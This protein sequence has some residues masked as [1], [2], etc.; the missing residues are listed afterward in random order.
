MIMSEGIGKIVDICRNSKWSTLCISLLFAVALFA[1]CCLFERFAMGMSVFSCFIHPTRIISVYTQKL[2]ISIFFASLCF[3][4]KR[5]YWVLY[6]LVINAIWIIAECVYMESF[7]DLM[8]DAYSLSMVSNLSGFESSIWM[9]IHSHYI[10]LF[11]PIFL[12]AV[13]VYFFDNRQKSNWKAFAICLLLALGL[14]T[15]HAMY[16]S[17]IYQTKNMDDVHIS[18]VWNPITS[19]LIETSTITYAHD[20]SIVHCFLR[21]GYEMLV[22]TEEDVDVDVLTRE[23]QPFIQPMD[24]V[25]QPKTKLVIFLVESLESW[26]IMPEV[27]PNIC[28]VIASDGSLYAPY[29]KRQALKGQSMDGQILVNTGILPLKNGASCFR[30]PYN[31]F[32]AIS[33][34]YTTSAIIVPGGTSVWN[35]GCMSR[36]MGID[37]NY[38]APFDDEGII[39]IY[40]QIAEQ[41][42]Y[43]M[44]LTSSSHSPFTEAADRSNIKLPDDMPELMKNYLKSINFT[45]RCLGKALDK[46]SNSENLKDITIVITSD[47]TIFSE[48][49]RQQFEKWC[50]DSGQTQYK[51]NVAYRPLMVLPGG[52]QGPSRIIL[53]YAYQ[54]DIY[55][56]I[57]HAIGCDSYFWKGWGVNLA[58]SVAALNRPIDEA[59]AYDMADKVLRS[60]WFELQN[61]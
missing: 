60:N 12:M 10:W 23:M 58:D 54:M 28:K 2:A 61:Y 45:D 29:I 25:P 8:I 38:V 21:V 59:A 39:E 15:G 40:E 35:Q 7:D 56:T 49:H 31:R 43:V 9:Y 34:L 32:P 36:A 20:Y 14:N 11:L 44:V 47:H 30:C 33:E 24:T 51:P 55:P 26:A 57:M 6:V 48:A 42:D 41:Y 17:H 50:K 22:N 52:G 4:F 16:L 27:T 37:T 46:I 3:L 18:D 53:Q 19:D 1:Q 5:K 13:A